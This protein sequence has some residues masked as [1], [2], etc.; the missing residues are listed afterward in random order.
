MELPT[1]L[2]ATE[3]PLKL[4]EENYFQT[5]VSLA[6]L[7]SWECNIV[8]VWV[9]EK[10]KIPIRKDSNW[11]GNIL[12]APHTSKVHCSYVHPPPWKYCVQSL[13]PSRLSVQICKRVWSYCLSKSPYGTSC[14]SFL[15]P[16]QL[17]RFRNTTILVER[18]NCW[19]RSSS[20]DL[21]I[22]AIYQRSKHQ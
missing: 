13:G 4:R 12:R 3:I 10:K 22:S 18:A 15:L 19:C 14:S 17:I 5:T 1:K 11:I 2:F 16:H 20:N 21:I 7:P 8:R 9:F 6:D